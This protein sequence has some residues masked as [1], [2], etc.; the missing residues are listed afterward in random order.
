MYACSASR[1]G[2]RAKRPRS[3]SGEQT[4]LP[5]GEE[6]SMTPIETRLRVLTWNLWWQYGPWEARLPAIAR[7]L[8]TLDAD[9]IAL[10]EVWHDGTRSQAAELAEPLGLHQ[11]YASRVEM[12]GVQFGNAILSRWP[13]S[14]HETMPLPA[15]DDVNELRL[16][17]RADIDGRRG[18]LQVF[19]PHLNWRFD[20]S[21]VRQEQVRTIARFVDGPPERSYPPI[22]C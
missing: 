8:A 5:M 22:L 16:V 11:V 1:S 2:W 4:M 6:A 14:F 18:P 19:P 10:Q 20:Q 3:L 7:T 21:E 9:V 12:D 13:I 17:L 15:P